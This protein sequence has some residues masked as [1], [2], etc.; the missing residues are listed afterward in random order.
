MARLRAIAAEADAT[1]SEDTDVRE[2]DA[3]LAREFD[4]LKRD[5]EA[6]AEQLR[7][8]QAKLDFDVD[9]GVGGDELP[10]HV[11]DGLA[12]LEESIDSLRAEMRAAGDET[13][14]MPESDS[15]Q[16]VG[17]AIGA[18]RDHLERARAALRALLDWAGAPAP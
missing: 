15:S 10:P 16:A 9:T 18:A 2:A 5:R 6:L 8:L 17:A 4:E 7:G 12:V 13:A 3:R 11:R 1:A 14:A